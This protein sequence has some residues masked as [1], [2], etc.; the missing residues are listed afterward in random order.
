[1]SDSGMGPQM[2]VLMLALISHGFWAQYPIRFD[3]TAMVPFSGGTSPRIALA[4]V[5]FPVPTVPQMM[6]REP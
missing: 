6:F 4:I 5:V 2:M 1:M 3:D